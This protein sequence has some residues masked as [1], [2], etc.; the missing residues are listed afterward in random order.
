[1]SSPNELANSEVIIRPMFATDL[2]HGFLETLEALTTVNLTRE[3][4]VEVYQRRMRTHLDTF[5]ALI[6]RQVVGTAT[7][8]IEQKYLHSGGYCGHIEDV[9]VNKQFQTHGIGSKLI[10]HCLQFCQDEGCYKVI[11]DCAPHLIG[12][13]EKFQFKTWSQGMRVDFPHE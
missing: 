12:Y 9:A 5:V 1:M 11:L 7:V 13:Y 3:Q 10:R 8:I 2:D 6:G 4:A